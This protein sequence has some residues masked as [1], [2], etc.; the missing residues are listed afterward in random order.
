MKHRLN[1]DKFLGNAPRIEER[2]LDILNLRFICVSS[3]AKNLC[4]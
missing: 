1:T 2:R 4:S 3:V